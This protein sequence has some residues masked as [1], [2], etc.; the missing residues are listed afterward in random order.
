MESGS[1][2][3]RRMKQKRLWTEMLAW[4]A[5]VLVATLFAFLGPDSAGLHHFFTHDSVILNPP[6]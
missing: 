4:M 1:P 5:A 3:L 2:T 6:R